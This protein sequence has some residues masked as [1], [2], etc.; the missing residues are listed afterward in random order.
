MFIWAGR[1][2]SVLSFTQRHEKTVSRHPALCDVD[3]VRGTH[4]CGRQQN[5][6]CDGY[7]EE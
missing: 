4:Q 6:Q 1:E 7:A 3:K 2:R 5:R